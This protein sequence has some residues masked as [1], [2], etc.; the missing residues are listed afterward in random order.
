MRINLYI[1]LL[2]GCLIISLISCNNKNDDE[3]IGMNIELVEIIDPPDIPSIYTQ[4]L[5]QPKVRIKNNGI[6]NIDSIGITYFVMLVD[7]SETEEYGPPTY[8]TN[9]INPGEEVIISLSKWDTIS[10]NTPLNDG[11]YWI[12]VK[13]GKFIP[14]GL[15]T[16]DKTFILEL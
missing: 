5:I 10:G 1:T 16:K 7:S 4:S 6:Y 13:L 2:V 15:T 12:Y 9:T 11:T 8:W 3:L 14:S